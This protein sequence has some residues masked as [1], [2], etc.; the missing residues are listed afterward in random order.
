MIRLLI[1]APSAVMRAGL[2]TLAASSPD[3]ELLGSFPDLAAVE[4]PAP[5]WSCWVRFRILRRSRICTPT[6]SSPP[7]RSK[8]S[9]RPPTGACRRW[10]C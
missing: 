7:F 4:D 5:T 2:E 1:A 10:C 8:T 6:S 9:R 3:V